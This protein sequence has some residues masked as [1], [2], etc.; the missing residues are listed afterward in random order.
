MLGRISV[1]S[2]MHHSS[3]RHWSASRSSPLPASIAAARCVRAAAL[4]DVL[5]VRAQAGGTRPVLVDPDGEVGLLGL[6]LGP[7][8]GQLGLER[9]AK[10]LERPLLAAELLILDED[11]RA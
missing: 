9:R 3:R 8:G 6:E 1:T 4:R 2:M 7:Q 5:S 11:G 10:P